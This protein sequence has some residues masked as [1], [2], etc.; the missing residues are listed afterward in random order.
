MQ[1][2]KRIGEKRKPRHDVTKKHARARALGS[3]EFSLTLSS[4]S[5]ASYFLSGWHYAFFF[6]HFLRHEETRSLVKRFAYSRFRSGREAALLNP[7]SFARM[8]TQLR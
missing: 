3:F 4:R 7:S 2:L 1:R 6:A 5:P 8:L